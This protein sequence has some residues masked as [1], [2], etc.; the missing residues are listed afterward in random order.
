MKER[1]TLDIK[2]LLKSTSTLIKHH[3]QLTKLK[4]ESFNVFSILQME[5]A[6]NKTHSNFIAELLNPNGSHLMGNVFLKLFLKAIEDETLDSTSTTVHLEYPIGL[7]DLDNETGGRID[8]LLKDQ[9]GKTISIENKIEAIDQPKQILRYTN[10]NKSNNKVYYLTKF[11]KDPGQDV[12]GEL[13]EGSGYWNITYKITIVAWLK[14]C[15]KEAAE[16]PLIR[17]SIKQYIVLI[18][19]L[20]GTMNNEEEAQLVELVSGNMEAAKFIVE[21]YESAKN[22]ICER[23]RNDVLSR[24]KEELGDKF[25]VEKDKEISTNYPKI[26]ISPK[27]PENPKIYFGIESFSSGGQRKVLFIGTFIHGDDGSKY[28]DQYKGENPNNY[29]CDREDMP[30]IDSV[31][32]S[33]GDPEFL[34][35][36]N[37]NQEAR[38]RGIEAVVDKTKD[39]IN[40]Y[41]NQVE[42]YLKNPLS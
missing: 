21:N 27:K 20:T 2:P 19:K 17:E 36:I 11:G 32:F 15:L 37:S 31:W 33:L 18:N 26:W 40:R 14:E 4:G 25:F 3:K 5:R 39:Y 38:K 28:L 30:E 10:F 13:V 41:G 9:S 23:F 42:T 34:Q 6:E 8:I 24:L 16:K 12:R 35:L 29:W 22:S 7:V 1:I